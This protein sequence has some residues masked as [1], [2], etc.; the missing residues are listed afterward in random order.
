MLPIAVARSSSGRVTQSQGEWA[1][2]GAFIPIDNALYSMPVGTHR[3]TAEPME[4]PFGL[5]TQVSRVG[6]RHHV[7]DGL[8]HHLTGNFQGKT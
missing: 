8:P 2:L 7:L 5:I 6:L 4:M 1:M 3:K